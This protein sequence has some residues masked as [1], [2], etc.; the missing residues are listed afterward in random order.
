MENSAGIFGLYFPKPVNHCTLPAGHTGPA[1]QKYCVLLRADRVVR[2]YKEMP[3]RAGPMCPALHY[4]PRPLQKTCHCEPVTDVTG[5]AIRTS[6]RRAALAGR[7]RTSAST[8]F[9]AS[10]RRPLRSSIGKRFVG[11]GLPDDPHR[12]CTKLLA[13]RRAGCPQPAARQPL[14]PPGRARGPCPTK[15]LRITPGGQGRP[16]LQR[17][18]L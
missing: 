6:L 17:N 2:P 7:G 13:L 15:I 11:V 8:A 5:A 14:H 4:P 10:G 9:G 1:L 12:T 18:A 3:C 16:P